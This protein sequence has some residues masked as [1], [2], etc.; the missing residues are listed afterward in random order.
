[1][2]GSLQSNMNR[3]GVD[4]SSKVRNTDLFNHFFLLK[5][6]CSACDKPI[7]GKVINAMRRAWHPEHFTCAHCDMELGSVTFFEHN[8]TP[9]CE[10]DY[11]ELFAP[12]CA[13]CN[14]PILDVSFSL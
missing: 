9:Y 14:G 5:G 8:N 13:Y 7:F 1:M 2:L 12:R 6:T 10:K 3:Q 11:H 4:T